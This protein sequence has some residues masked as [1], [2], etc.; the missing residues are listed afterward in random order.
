MSKLK[1]SKAM[2]EV[3]AW[4][5]ECDKEVAGMGIGAAVRKRL[6]DSAAVAERLGFRILSPDPRNSLVVA[7][8][9]AKYGKA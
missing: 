9:K 8:G 1:E 3:R 4:K 2:R 7:E 5:A 6:E